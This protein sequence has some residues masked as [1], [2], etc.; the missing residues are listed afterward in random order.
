MVTQGASDGLNFC[1]GRV[2]ADDY[3]AS[4]PVVDSTSEADVGTETS[5]PSSEEGTADPYAEES[6]V[7]HQSFWNTCLLPSRKTVRV[8]LWKKLIYPV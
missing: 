7:V 2:T 5:P 3:C 4:I 6:L 8:I 1:D